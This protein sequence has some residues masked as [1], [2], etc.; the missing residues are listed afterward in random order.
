M[1]SVAAIR[2]GPSLPPVPNTLS[3]KSST[4]ECAVGYSIQKQYPNRQITLSS[5]INARWHTGRSLSSVPSNQ[6]DRRS[7]H[8]FSS[9]QQQHQQSTMKFL[10]SFSFATL[11]IIASAEAGCFRNSSHWYVV[12]IRYCYPLPFKEQVHDRVRVEDD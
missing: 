9:K 6:A 1:L 12:P 11:W 4:P 2:G 10:V 8:K 3:G 7:E 5:S